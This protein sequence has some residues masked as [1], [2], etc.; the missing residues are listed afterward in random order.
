MNKQLFFSP[1]VFEKRHCEIQTVMAE[2]GADVL[3]ID[4]PEFIFHLIGYS[5]SEGFQQFCALPRFGAPMMILRCVD[6]GTCHE[7]GDVAPEDVI[8]YPDWAN[9]V[10]VLKSELYKRAIAH[11]TIA[12][13]RDSYNM[14]LNR[15]DAL[16][17][18]FPE[19][20]FVDI[21]QTLREMRA[22]KTEEEIAYL[23]KAS[24]IADDGIRAI[25][26][27][28]RS[29]LSARDCVSLAAKHII[30]SGG[31]A[32]VIG[33]VTRALDDNKMHALVDDEPLKEG[34]L[35][36]V[37]MIP[38]YRGYS[39]RLMRPVY[40]GEPDRETQQRAKRIVALQ[41]Q[42]IAAMK[43]GARASDVDYILRDGMLKSELKSK[44]E[45]ISGYSLGYY[46]QFTCRSSDFSYVF[47]PGDDWVLRRDMVFHMY[48][49]SNGLAFSETV[50]VGDKG[51]VRLT[52]SPRKLFNV[53][54]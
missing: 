28:F 41:D 7:Y 4:Q 16:R 13:D 31:D 8:G 43:P 26:R 33:P 27:E 47:R 53:N 1:S 42:Q 24:E 30:L 45:N 12:I 39:A 21:S 44:Y 25:L 52:Q 23:R 22:V 37:E 46:Q 6:E 9:P 38:Q 14:T 3:L 5:M 54:G 15:F 51:G 18:A 10:E 48:T 35:L 32:G 34:D 20:N 19:A 50:V 11:S 2:V 36:H 40:V 29:G 17:A 49:V